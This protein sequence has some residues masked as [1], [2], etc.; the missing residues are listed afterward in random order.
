MKMT[1]KARRRR[2]TAII[3]ILSEMSRNGWANARYDDYHPLEVELKQLEGTCTS[4]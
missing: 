1:P 2:R 4:S 3:R